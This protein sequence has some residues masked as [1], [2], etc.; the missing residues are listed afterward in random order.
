MPGHSYPVEVQADFLEKVTKAKPVAALAELIWNAVD[1]DATEV[2]VS[3]HQNEMNAITSIVVADNG[4]G[5]THSEAADCFQR[6]GGSWKRSVRLTRGQRRVLH[7]QEGRGRFKA[8]ALGKFADWRVTYKRDG[9]LWS[10]TVMM[11]A[12]NIRQIEISDEQRA[13]D[14]AHEGVSLTVS[15]LYR[16]YR[17]LY[18]D[19]TLQN[20]VEIFAL[21]LSDYQAV[22]ITIG[23]RKLDP[24]A[25]IVSRKPL[26]LTDIVVE[27]KAFP[28][29]LEIIEW[30]ALTSRALYLC[31]ENGFPLV[32]VD[33]RFH[34]GSFQ[35][36]AYLRTG[37]TAKLVQDG[38]LD[39]AEAS[40]PMKAAVDE[41]QRAITSNF[42][43]R[44]AEEA[45]TV[46]DEWKSA[47][48]YP[49][50]GEPKS[51]VETVERQV[52]DIVAVQMAQHVE[53]FSATPAT[54][55]AF[56]LRLLRQAIENGP[57]ELQLI[58]EEVLNLPVRKREELAELLRDVSLAAVIGAAKLVTERLKFLQGLDSLLF[59]AEPKKRLKERSQLH[60]IIAQNCWLFGEEFNLSVDDQGLTEVLR[61]HKKIIGDDTVIDEPV[62]HISQSRGIVDLMLSK[63]S[64]SY[65]AQSLTHLVVE[66]KAPK[67][68]VDGDEINQIEH[69]AF[70]IVKDERFSR[71]QTKWVFWVISDE[72]GDY[73]TSRVADDEDGL[74][75]KKGN[76]SIY[77]KTWSQVLDENRARLQF[78]Q[79]RLQFQADRTASLNHLRERYADFLKGVL[80]DTESEYGAPQGIEGESHETV[81]AVADSA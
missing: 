75:H 79:E 50:V 2:N 77:A 29:R 14:G 69:Y 15:E 65:R 61:K 10:Y 4:H 32:S 39:F 68:K 6:L 60:R 43:E 18:G 53:N 22:S 30:R 12:A 46:V 16:D 36:S 19:T 70:S 23:G 28:V 42:R 33:R 51:T 40:P 20:L 81:D 37:F 1:A 66:L 48:I 58:F 11:N 64:R 45:K 8:L 27:G 13:P 55:K 72:L 3:F 56:S 5:I 31:D 21:Y 67:V 24:A 74:I 26:N 57:A 63:A 80:E 71:T 78:F 44:A 38:E 7:G 52:F 47:E 35:F 54:S 59:D 17:G 34:V 49:Y 62:R 73:A 9:E 25:A 41:A 76:L